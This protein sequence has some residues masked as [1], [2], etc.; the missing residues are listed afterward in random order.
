[1]GKLFIIN[2]ICNDVIWLSFYFAGALVGQ[3]KMIGVLLAIPGMVGLVVMSTANYNE[4]LIK[5]REIW[6]R[7]Y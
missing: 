1:V 5:G 2:L 6:R 4:G 7:N 3:G